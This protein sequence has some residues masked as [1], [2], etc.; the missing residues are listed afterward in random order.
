MG[1]CASPNP[2]RLLRFDSVGETL[3]EQRA[4]FTQS[5]GRSDRVFP[6]VW[7]GE[8][9]GEENCGDFL[10]GHTTN[11][12]YGRREVAVALSQ[13]AHTVKGSGGF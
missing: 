10:A 1:K 12:D 5:F 7:V 6:G 8:V 2:V 4:F 11:F 9:L 13:V 3:G